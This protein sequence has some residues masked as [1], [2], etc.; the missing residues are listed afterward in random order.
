MLQIIAVVISLVVAVYIFKDKLYS[1][2]KTSESAPVVS[3]ATRNIVEKMESTRKRIIIF[4]G[5]Q[6]GTAEEYA[7]KI[8]KGVCFLKIRPL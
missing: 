7:L 5:S 1:Q 2:E 8:A 3:S 4:Y 6:T